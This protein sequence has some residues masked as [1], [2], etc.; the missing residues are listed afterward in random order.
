MFLLKRRAQNRVMESMQNLKEVLDSLNSW[1]YV[2]DTN[3]CHLLYLNR[4]A[5]E[6]TPGAQAGRLCCQALFEREEPCSPCIIHEMAKKEDGAIE[7]YHSRLDKGVIATGT[8]IPWGDKEAY[9]LV[10]QDISRYKK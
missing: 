5:N 2:V 10:C 4:R 1:I 7:V 6:L 8:R 9:L 3:S